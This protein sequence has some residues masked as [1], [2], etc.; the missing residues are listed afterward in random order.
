MTIH[1]DKSTLPQGKATDNGW[2]SREYNSADEARLAFDEG[3]IAVRLD[4]D[5]MF[6]W[7]EQKIDVFHN[8]GEYIHTFEIPRNP[9]I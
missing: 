4:D 8:D 3:A 1:K 7:F 9:P 5:T 2:L 6:A